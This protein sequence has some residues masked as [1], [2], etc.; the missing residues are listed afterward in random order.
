MPTIIPNLHLRFA[1]TC[2]TVCFLLAITACMN[3]QQSS[4]KANQAG[5]TATKTDD[6]ATQE[7]A[8]A[9]T[10]AAVGE[11]AEKTTENVSAEVKSG[12]EPK[13][14]FEVPEGMLV[15][16]FEV[17]GMHCSGC[18]NLLRQKVGGMDH[19]TKVVAS[20]PHERMWVLMEKDGP[21]NADIVKIV[22]DTASSYKIKPL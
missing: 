12:E 3:Q 4:S 13:V 6:E 9:A 2:L 16:V 1:L 11:D 21:S 5:Q 7:T 19:V 17:K 8:T 14:P 15:R 18:E 20:K 10:A 22:S